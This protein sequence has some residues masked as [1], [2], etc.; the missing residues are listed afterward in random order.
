MSDF[1]NPKNKMN[2]TDSPIFVFNHPKALSFSGV[3]KTEETHSSFIRM[4]NYIDI[5]K[6][7]NLK[8]AKRF[9]AIFNENFDTINIRNC[10]K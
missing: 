8:N 10:F 1:N 4:M 7:S 3:Q 2:S 5:A 9:I 6:E